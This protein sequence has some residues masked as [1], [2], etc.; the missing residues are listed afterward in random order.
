MI[1]HSLY[2]VACIWTN[3]QDKTKW[4]NTEHCETHTILS[5]VH[6]MFVNFKSMHQTT[7]TKEE[8]EEFNWVQKYALL[9]MQIANKTDHNHFLW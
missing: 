6:F 9:Q 4:T 5:S 1:L 7:T 2:P 3:G 8:E